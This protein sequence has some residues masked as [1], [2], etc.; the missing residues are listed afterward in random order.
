MNY[1]GE[2]E[3]FNRETDWSSKEK[4]L[5]PSFS[6]DNRYPEFKYGPCYKYSS[7]WFMAINALYSPL[8]FAVATKLF[9][10]ADEMLSCKSLDVNGNHNEK[11][12]HA[13][14]FIEV[15]SV[16]N[17]FLMKLLSRPEFDVSLIEERILE[18]MAQAGNTDDIIILANIL[19]LSKMIANDDR[20]NNEIKNDSDDYGDF[21][22]RRI[23]QY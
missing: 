8:S 22:K 16:Q 20:F 17:G 7:D 21:I 23:I 13:A 14:D 2:V 12:P 10:L 15:D 6:F 11:C 4:Q 5:R 19:K 3:S 18:L 1:I 9:P